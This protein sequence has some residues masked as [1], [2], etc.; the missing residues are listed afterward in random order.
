M[1]PQELNMMKNKVM[2]MMLN[3]RVHYISLER[4]MSSNKELVHD[5][6]GMLFFH[7]LL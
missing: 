4:I 5:M 1:K 3:F 2:I 7:M 6:I